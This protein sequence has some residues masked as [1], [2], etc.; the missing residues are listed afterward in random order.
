MTNPIIIAVA[1]L[2]EAAVAD[3]AARMTKCLER[4][5]VELEAAD[6]DVSE[7]APRP[8]TW[9]S[10]EEYKRTQARRDFFAALTEYA[11]GA[12][13]LHDR[14]RRVWSDKGAAGLLKQAEEAAVASYDAYVAKLV[15]K[16]GEATA[17]ELSP[18]SDGNLW[19][20]SILR[21]VGT[22]G[23]ERRWKTQRIVNWSG[24]GKMFFQ[25]PTRELRAA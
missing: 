17:A 16:V 19:E 18:A 9:M 12:L 6:W 11:D 20:Y 21:V 5:R 3:A 14:N 1:P 10:R 22:D 23:V 24:L 15:A 4:A 2:R 13:T 7:L 8:H 25:W